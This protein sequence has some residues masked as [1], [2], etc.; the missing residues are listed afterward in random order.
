M[1]KDTI[2]LT[3]ADVAK[4][5]KNG[6]SLQLAYQRINVLHWTNER[7]VTQKPRGYGRYPEYRARCEANGISRRL[8]DIRTCRGMDPERACTEKPNE[9]HR[10][11]AMGAKKNG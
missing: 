7:A 8:F 4:A 5:T 10:Q 2:Q 6:I 11:N 1:G 9:K 3:G